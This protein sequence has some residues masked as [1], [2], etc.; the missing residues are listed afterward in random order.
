MPQKISLYYWNGAPNIGDVLSEF[1][2]SRLAEGCVRFKNP[3]ISYK[4]MLYQALLFSLRRP[5]KFRE[6]YS[7]KIKIGEKLF[8]AI[9]S[10]LDFA[11]KNCIVWGSGFRE[12]SSRT[13]ASEIV[14]VRGY[15]TRSRLEPKFGNIAV[16]DPALLLPLILPKEKLSKDISISVIPHFLEQSDFM[17]IN[18][19]GLTVINIMSNDINNFVSQVLK[20]KL[21]LSSSLHGLIIAHAYGVPALWIRNKY[22]GS[23]VFKYYDYFS[24][25]EWDSYPELNASDVLNYNEGQIFELFEEHSERSLPSQ[26]LI[27]D[28]QQALLDC[29][30]YNLNASFRIL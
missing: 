1:I 9:G 8:F 5:N 24:S 16:G 10:I 17:R 4:G 30:P 12:F 22:V 11:P 27:Q 6:Y 18:R 7:Q 2:V 13:K 28:R 29:F 20:S 19:N 15:L 25:L 21:V 14:A 23:S 3:F 26:K